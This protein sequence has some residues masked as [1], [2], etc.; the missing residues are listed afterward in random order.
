M[1]K[2]LYIPSGEYIQFLK[3]PVQNKGIE[4]TTSWEKSQWRSVW[5]ETIEDVIIQL[6][7]AGAEASTKAKHKIPL[8]VELSPNEFEIIEEDHELS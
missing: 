6:C 3:I 2:L 1:T 8:N 7:K 4:Y 5:E